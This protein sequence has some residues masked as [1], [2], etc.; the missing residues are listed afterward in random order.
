MVTMRVDP[1]DVFGAE[2]LEDAFGEKIRPKVKGFDFKCQIYNS[3][4]LCITAPLLDFSDRGNDDELIRHRYQQGSVIDAIDNARNGLPERYGKGPNYQQAKKR[5]I[6]EFIDPVELSAEV[7]KEHEGKTNNE[8]AMRAIQVT[9]SR[10]E[11]RKIEVED[12]K[13]QGMTVETDIEVYIETPVPRLVWRVADLL[14]KNRKKG[15]TEI[16]ANE[17]TTEAAAALSRLDLG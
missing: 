6:L 1:R 8:L 3:S 4:S 16:E 14:G 11:H 2:A 17:G 13:N 12:P 5:F 15:R 7:L 9:P 10:T